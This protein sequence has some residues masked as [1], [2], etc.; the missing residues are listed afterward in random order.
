M[1]RHVERQLARARMAAPAGDATADVRDV[2]ERVVRVVER[3]PD[4]R[5]V[6][7]G[8]RAARSCAHAST[9]TT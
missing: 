7:G 2:V 1:H 8:R 9:P 4:G 6:P 5:R 3:T